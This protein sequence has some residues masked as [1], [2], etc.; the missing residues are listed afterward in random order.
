MKQIPVRL[1]LLSAIFLLSS[2]V[3]SAEDMREAQVKARESK[4]ELLE[5]AKAERQAAEH[6]AADSRARILKDRKALRSAV[7]ELKKK[8]R[9]LFDKFLH[10]GG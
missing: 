3:G 9:Q 8:N 5:K 2:T 1:M 6:E 4:I 7:A 10:K